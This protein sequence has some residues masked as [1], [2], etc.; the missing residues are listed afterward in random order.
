MGEGRVEG[1]EG[2]RGVRLPE[3]AVGEVFRRFIMSTRVR[4]LVSE[5]SWLGLKGRFN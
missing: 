3:T 4:L 2:G 5:S 1:I